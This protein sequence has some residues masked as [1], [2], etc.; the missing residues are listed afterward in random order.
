VNLPYFYIRAN[1]ADIQQ[2]FRL[3]QANNIGT[4]IARY[5]V[6]KG[7]L[8]VCFLVSRCGGDYLTIY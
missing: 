6:N 7:I 2:E 5:F 1:L 4:D 8:S 3:F